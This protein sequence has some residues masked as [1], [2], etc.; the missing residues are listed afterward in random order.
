MHKL[1]AVLLS[2]ALVAT[3]Q[4]T[5]RAVT[6]TATL[7]SIRITARPGQVMTR[8]FRLT[9]DAD[10]PKTRFKSHMQDWWRNEDGTQSFYLDPGT[11]TQSC[12]R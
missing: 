4:A 8:E 9:L 2:V 12:G 7:G 3:F 6:F 5:A 10:Q 1:H 11:L